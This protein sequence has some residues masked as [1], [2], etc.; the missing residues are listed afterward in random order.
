MSGPLETQLGRT[1]PAETEV[2]AAIMADPDW[3]HGMLWGEPRPGHP[4]GPVVN[5]VRDVL[6]N[7]ERYAPPGDALARERLRLVALLHDACKVVTAQRRDGA[8]G[9]N[10]GQLARRLAERHVTDETVLEIV[11]LHDV[12]YYCWRALDRGD[13]EAAHE[14]ARELVERLGER[15]DLYLA[16]YRCDSRIAGKRSDPLEW[17]EQFCG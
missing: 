10:H 8:H 1:I 6:D 12:A 4:E 17:F 11:E 15:L 13:R 16:F 9:P 5:H 3:I 14:R 2:E 7:V